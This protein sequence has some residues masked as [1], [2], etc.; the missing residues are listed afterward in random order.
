MSFTP[1]TTSERSSGH[2][3]L[4]ALPIKSPD[5]TSEEGRGRR[6]PAPPAWQGALPIEA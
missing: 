5:P 1:T 6:R 4:G 2:T 3:L